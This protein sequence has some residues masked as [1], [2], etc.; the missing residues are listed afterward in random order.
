MK[1]IQDVN[2]NVIN[3]IIF[4]MALIRKSGRGMSTRKNL[5]IFEGKKQ[6]REKSYV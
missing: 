4:S 1:N 3:E 2:L 5:T 6:F